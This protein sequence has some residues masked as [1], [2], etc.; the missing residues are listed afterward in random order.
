M[1]HSEAKHSEEKESK[2]EEKPNPLIEARENL[3]WTGRSRQMQLQNLK[4]VLELVD[5]AIETN[6]TPPKSQEAVAEFKMPW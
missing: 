6:W 5:W 3:V 2:P 1:K 4:I